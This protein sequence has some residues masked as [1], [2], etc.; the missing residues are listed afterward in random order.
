M[1]KKASGNPLKATPRRSRAEF[2]V[3]LLSPCPFPAANQGQIAAHPPRKVFAARA[4][5]ING[6]AG[7][8]VVR[9]PPGATATAKSAHI[10]LA[11]P[12]M[13]KA[14]F[15]SQLRSFTVTAHHAKALQTAARMW[16]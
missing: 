14:T 5:D 1:D 2:D 9:G 8:G 3:L 11:R 16:T 10:W 4:V 12:A 6:F 15:R 7:P 13:A